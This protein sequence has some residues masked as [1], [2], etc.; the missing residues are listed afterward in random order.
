[1]N[2]SVSS[3]QSVANLKYMTLNFL[4]SALHS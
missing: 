3:C 4:V 1:M 2:S